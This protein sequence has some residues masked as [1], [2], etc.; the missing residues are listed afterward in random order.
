MDSTG[1]KAVSQY[2]SSCGTLELKLEVRAGQRA[3]FR[4]AFAVSVLCANRAGSDLAVRDEE[5]VVIVLGVLLDP[6]QHLP[7]EKEEREERR[8]K[9]SQH[10]QQHPCGHKERGVLT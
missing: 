10:R 6:V 8:R 7:A 4:A 3:C 5:P 9:E 1:K 2:Y